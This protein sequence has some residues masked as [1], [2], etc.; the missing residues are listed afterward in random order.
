MFSG[1]Q[2]A[3][4]RISARVSARSRDFLVKILEENT[5]YVIKNLAKTRV[6]ARVLLLL[7]RFCRDK[8]VKAFVLRCFAE[9]NA[10]KRA[11][12]QVKFFGPEPGCPG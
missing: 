6:L 9:A 11:F 7:H 5:I 3:E 1:G 10:P 8:S 2:R 12:R 4:T